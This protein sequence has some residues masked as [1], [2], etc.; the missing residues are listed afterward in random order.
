[1]RMVIA[2][3]LA[4]LCVACSPGG[5]QRQFSSPQE[6]AAALVD[7]AKAADSRA[8]LDILGAPAEPVVD[9]GDP[10][11]DRNARERFA[12]AFAQAHAFVDAPDDTRIL[13]VG[14]DQWPFPFPLVRA[15]RGWHF[16]TS[17]GIDEIVNRRVGA[18]ELDT[19]QACL[20]F[21]DAQREYYMRNPQQ[22]ALM[23]FA[24]RLFSSPDQRDGL[25]W[26]TVDGEAPSPL[27][28]SFA[29]A[30]SEGYFQGRTA[31]DEPY[32]G[33]VYRLL[34]RQGAN[35]A[36]GAYDYLVGDRMLGGFALIAI[37]ADYGNSGVM[38]F[39]V[40]HEGVVFSRDLGPETAKVAGAIEAFDPDTGWTRELSIA[41]E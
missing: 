36:G 23:H 18:N 34:T 37:P 1:M 6:A 17:V 16:D 20:A 32:H 40:N 41:D 15:G 22:D 26:P 29:V 8:L 3:I 21:V 11:Q 9:S 10:V 19:I 35:A 24:R 5:S 27:G 7:A 12:D 25:Y 33:Y 28:E 2:M 38:T 4:T 14:A 39:V 30:R 13:T 31:A